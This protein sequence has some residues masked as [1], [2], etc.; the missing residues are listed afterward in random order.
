MIQDEGEGEKIIFG[1]LE[2]A[3]G[4]RHLER[5]GGGV[6]GRI[7]ESGR[8]GEGDCGGGI[9]TMSTEKGN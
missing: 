8:N 6:I 5:R 2:T 4:A 9:L 3:P 7:V 1:C